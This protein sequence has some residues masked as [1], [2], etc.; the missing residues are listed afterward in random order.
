[1]DRGSF[2]KKLFI[3]YPNSF[4]ENNISIWKEA[5]EEV[6]AVDLDFKALFFKMVRDYPHTNIAPAPSWFVGYLSS[7]KSNKNEKNEETEEDNTPLTQ[8]QLDAIRNFTDKF[9][10]KFPF[11]NENKP[12]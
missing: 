11:E 10:L 8:E 5:Y 7:V 2:L 4:S 12:N 3:M 1:M 9:G 6:L